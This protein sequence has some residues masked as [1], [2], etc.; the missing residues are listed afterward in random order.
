MKDG[1]VV[2][3]ENVRYYNEEEKNDPVFAEK[4]AKV[5]DVYVNDAFGAAHRAHASTEGVARVVARR[6]GKCAAGLLM[7]RELKFL[8]DELGKAGASVCGH[9]RRRKGF[10]QNQGH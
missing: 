8:G 6:G 3:L 5:A 9:S 4:L 1:D 2:L 10:R 7:E